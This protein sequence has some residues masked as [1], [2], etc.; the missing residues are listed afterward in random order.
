MDLN[1][2]EDGGG[3]LDISASST[4]SIHVMLARYC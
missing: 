4:G 1:F 2:Q 3:E